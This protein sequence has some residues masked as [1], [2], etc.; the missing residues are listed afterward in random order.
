MKLNEINYTSSG[1]VKYLMFLKLS[2][3]FEIRYLKKNLH[4]KFDNLPSFRASKSL[5]ADPTTNFETKYKSWFFTLILNNKRKNI[6]SEQTP[7]TRLVRFVKIQIP[8]FRFGCPVGKKIYSWL[9]L[10]MSAAMNSRPLCSVTAS[11]TVFFSGR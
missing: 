3:I 6:T 11:V 2:N 9:L 10:N 4:D 1:L 8:N 7:Q 5:S